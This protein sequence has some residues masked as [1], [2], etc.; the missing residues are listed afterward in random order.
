MMMTRKRKI[1]IA[2]L[3]GLLLLW[4]GWLFCN[5]EA[6]CPWNP[7]ID[8]VC[9]SGYS[10]EAFRKI[11]T[12]M[13][14]SEVESFMPVPLSVWTNSEGRVFVWYTG[15]G[16]CRFGDFAWQCRGVHVE[17]GVVQEVVLMTA[18]D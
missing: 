15:D 10:E 9:A 11:R 1:G 7:W 2:C 16:K 8:T 13:T 14:M 17:S 12:G 4:G 5:L 6:E 3:L 18:G